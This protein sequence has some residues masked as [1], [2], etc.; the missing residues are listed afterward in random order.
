MS[1]VRVHFGVDATL[2]IQISGAI[3]ELEFVV[4]STPV[5]ILQLLFLVFFNKNN[6]ET[7]RQCALD[8]PRV[9]LFGASVPTPLL[10]RHHSGMWDRILLCPKTS[11][12]VIV[13]QHRKQHSDFLHFLR[14]RY[15][16]IGYVNVL[17][18]PELR[19][20]VERED[21]RRCFIVFLQENTW[22]SPF[23]QFR[24]QESR[25]LV[26]ASK[27]LCRFQ[28]ERLLVLDFQTQ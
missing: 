18:K 27:V 7:C 8:N 25:N 10:H 12:C 26:Y 22:T 13:N 1:F 2:S 14:V 28:F 4:Y 15:F 24:I 16:I 21:L 20:N 6:K 17:E 23:S 9:L 5:I 19:Q 3:L 11:W